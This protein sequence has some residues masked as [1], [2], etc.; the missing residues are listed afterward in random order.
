MAEPSSK[1]PRPED[2]KALAT[3]LA[4]R[5]KR[6]R[7]ANF[8]RVVLPILAGIVHGLIARALFGSDNAQDFLGVMTT[9]FIV[10][11]P[12]SIGM[13]VVVLG[14]RRERMSLIAR[15]STAVVSA[16]SASSCGFRST[17]ASPR[18]VR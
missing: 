11:V 9:S 10:L 15:L 17:P 16:S 3:E 14:E 1:L 6:R 5:A 8:E 18:S 12:L 13:L 2:E 4:E 7:A